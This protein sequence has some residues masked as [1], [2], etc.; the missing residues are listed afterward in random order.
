MRDCG[1]LTCEDAKQ[2]TCLLLRALKRMK[3]VGSWHLRDRLASADALESAGV[4]VMM[5]LSAAP[6]HSCLGAAKLVSTRLSPMGSIRYPDA[7]R[8]ETL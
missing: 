6:T 7:L 4:D 5:V 8:R 3:I 2:R 1:H